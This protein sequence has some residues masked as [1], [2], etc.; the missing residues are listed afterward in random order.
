MYFKSLMK[1]Q[2]QSIILRNRLTPRSRYFVLADAGF[3]L[4]IF[5]FCFQPMLVSL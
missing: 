4:I 1:D 2:K 5:Y 3:S